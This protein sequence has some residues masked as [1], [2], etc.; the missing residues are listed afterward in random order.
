MLEFLKQVK[1]QTALPLPAENAAAGTARNS[2]KGCYD[3][4]AVI[5]QAAN[6]HRLN[7]R[8]RRVRM[9]CTA[10]CT[11]QAASVVAVKSLPLIV[12]PGFV[13]PGIVAAFR[14]SR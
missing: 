12:M 5:H 11:P 9:P 8:S 1:Y 6:L 7:R 14:G 13:A 3:P 4:R 2:R 10:F